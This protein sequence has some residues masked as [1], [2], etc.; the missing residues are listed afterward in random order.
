MS[1][2]GSLFCRIRRLGKMNPTKGLL[3]PSVSGSDLVELNTREFLWSHSQ[4]HSPPWWSTLRVVLSCVPLAEHSEGKYNSLSVICITL[5][6]HSFHFIQIEPTHG[7]T[8]VYV[9]VKVSLL[10]SVYLI[11]TNKK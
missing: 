8:G 7:L 3:R 2:L 5:R 4:R 1:I 10:S 6:P 11:I 9:Y